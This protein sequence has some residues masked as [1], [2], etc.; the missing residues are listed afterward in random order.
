[1]M[2]TEIYPENLFHLDNEINFLKLYLAKIAFPENVF[3]KNV[4]LFLDNVF[5]FKKIL[6]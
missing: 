2:A 6:N 1:M 5:L 3:Y 4:K